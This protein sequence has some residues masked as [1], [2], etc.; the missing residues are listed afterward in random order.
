MPE[1]DRKSLN[2]KQKATE[3]QN[4]ETASQYQIRPSIDKSFPIASIRE[5]I[6]EVLLQILDGGLK[7]HLMMLIRF[8]GLLISFIFG[9]NI[10]HV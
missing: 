6:N 5:I 9:S 2:E 8:S 7:Y 10:M 4:N 1:Q 3:N